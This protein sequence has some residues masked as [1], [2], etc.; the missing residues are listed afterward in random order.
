MICKKTLSFLQ[1][2]HGA[3]CK[4]VENTCVSTNY[5]KIL[6]KIN[7]KTLLRMVCFLLNI[8]LLLGG[9]KSVEIGWGRCL[10]KTQ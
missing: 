1:I 5:L 3:M 2:A 7:Q 10:G 9:S 4:T 8:L 6:I